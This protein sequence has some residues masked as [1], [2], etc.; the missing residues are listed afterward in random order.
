[1]E[2]KEER[3]M[4]IK[5]GAIIVG[6]VLCVTG[7]YAQ[8]TEKQIWKSEKWKIRKEAM[9]KEMHKQLNLT[10]EQ[11]KQ[12][13]ENRK[14]HHQQ[15]RKLIKDL[16]AKRKELKEELQKQEFNMDKVKQIH[17]KVKDLMAKKADQRLER[18]LEVRLILK[19]EQFS[20]F[21]K[22]R[23]KYRRQKHHGPKK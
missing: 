4:K 22:L 16:N 23:G 18:I 6:L 12:L 7:A 10:P 21:M 3:I 11:K 14:K 17:S 20:K 15:K 2:Q 5:Y 8:E 13:D 19:P 1:M 9:I